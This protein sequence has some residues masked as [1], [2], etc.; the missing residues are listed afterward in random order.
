ME[1][2]VLDFCNICTLLGTVLVAK[3]DFLTWFTLGLYVDS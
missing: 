3:K 2:W 1:I